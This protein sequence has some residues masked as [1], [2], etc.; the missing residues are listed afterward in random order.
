MAT[1]RIRHIA[2]DF[3]PN[4]R[5]SDNVLGDSGIKHL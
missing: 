1:V 5:Y 2:P 4:Q 3:A